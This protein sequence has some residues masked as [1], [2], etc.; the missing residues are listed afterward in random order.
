[1]VPICWFHSPE[2]LWN[3]NAIYYKNSFAN[4]FHRAAAT[5]EPTD[6]RLLLQFVNFLIFQF[7]N[8]IFL[9]NKI[10]LTK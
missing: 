9:K 3:L 7:L 2:G 1:M 10:T 6:N 5:M 8:N 4:R